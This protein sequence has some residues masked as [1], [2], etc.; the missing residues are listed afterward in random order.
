MGRIFF[1]GRLVWKDQALGPVK[2]ER[3]DMQRQNGVGSQRP[4]HVMGGV[5]EPLGGAHPM[6]CLLGCQLSPCVQRTLHSECFGPVCPLKTAE[7]PQATGR[8][9]VLWKPEDLGI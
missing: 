3:K 1:H 5:S 6:V 2:D 9:D 4:A 7:G 8:L